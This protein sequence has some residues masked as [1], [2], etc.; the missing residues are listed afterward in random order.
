[1]KMEA[2]ICDLEVLVF[3]KTMFWEEWIMVWK[4]AFWNGYVWSAECFD[5]ETHFG[6]GLIDGKFGL[7]II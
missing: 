3:W 7:A 1:M 6:I 4:S 2:C 5:E